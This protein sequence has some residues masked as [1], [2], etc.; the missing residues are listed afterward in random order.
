MFV[1]EIGQIMVVGFAIDFGVPA[2]DTHGIEDDVAILGRTADDD[3]IL[4][5]LDN[6]PALSPLARCRNAVPGG[7]G[8]LPMT[9]Q[10]GFNS[11]ICPAR[12]PLASYGIG[13]L[14]PKI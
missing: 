11:I 12:S 13:L 14:R 4:L 9:T 1:V 7:P 10:S 6:Q 8:D 5:Q 2:A 3:A